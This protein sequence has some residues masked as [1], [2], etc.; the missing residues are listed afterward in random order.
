MIGQTCPSLIPFNRV[1]LKL[2]S[3]MSW[4][5][6]P[7]KH[8]HSSVFEEL[9]KIPRRWRSIS[10]AAGELWHLAHPYTCTL[11]QQWLTHLQNNL[12]QSGDINQ[13]CYCC[14][15]SKAI[16]TKPPHCTPGYAPRDKAPGET[17]ENI[18]VKFRNKTVWAVSFTNQK[19]HPV[20]KIHV[21]FW[22]GTHLQPCRHE[23]PSHPAAWGTL[24]SNPSFPPAL[25]SCRETPHLLQGKKFSFQHLGINCFINPSQ[26]QRSFQN[27]WNCIALGIICWEEIKLKI[28]SSPLNKTALYSLSG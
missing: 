13:K 8:Y 21:I 18:W 7:T 16:L 23:P 17:G 9:L 11:K 2:I 19:I 28:N 3:Q 12:A 20:N 1:K 22:S 24:G 6:S 25:G 14:F 10:A 5:M 26:T 4:L 15:L 27:D